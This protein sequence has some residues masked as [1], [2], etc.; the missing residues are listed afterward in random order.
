[1]GKGR[2][3]IVMRIDDVEQYLDAID[4]VD[5]MLRVENARS[6]TS[7]LEIES[8]ASEP[9]NL[10][11]PSSEADPGLRMRMDEF[12]EA[13]RAD[14]PGDG[15]LGPWVEPGASE[16]EPAAPALRGPAVRE[17][18]AQPAA[19][20]APPV[21]HE[22]PPQPA[23]PE[24]RVPAQPPKPFNLREFMKEVLAERGETAAARLHELD[25]EGEC[26]DLHGIQPDMQQ[27]EEQQDEDDQR[28]H[29]EGNPG[30]EQQDD[31]SR[32]TR[33]DLEAKVCHHFSM[34]QR[35]AEDNKRRRLC[36]KQA[37]PRAPRRLLH[38]YAASRGLPVGQFLRMLMVGL[39]LPILNALIFLNNM[40]PFSD[41]ERLH[42]T[43]FYSG[44]GRIAAT[45]EQNDCRVG[46]F[47]HNRH[48]QHEDILTAEGL[49]TGL[50]LA[51]NTASGLTTWATKCSSWIF[52]CR[53]K[54]GRSSN[55]PLGDSSRQWVADGNTMAARNVLLMALCS[56]MMTSWMHEHPKSSCLGATKFV[57]WLK[58]AL[59]VSLPDITSWTEAFT[60]MG[61]FGHETKKPTELL[62]SHSWILNLTRTVPEEHKLLFDSSH[63]VRH[64]PDA[65]HSGRRRVSGAE[66]LQDSQVYPW[67]FAKAVYANFAEFKAQQ[68]ESVE[69]ELSDDA[70]MPWE[71][72]K[73]ASALCD[74]EESRLS[75]LDDMLGQ[76]PGKLLH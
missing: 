46:C 14:R 21:H 19:P 40:E 34:V 63:G 68:E 33:A 70:E 24:P 45:F 62:G 18:P 27:D 43:E 37:L 9:Y 55:D 6:L 5:D 28:H 38:H 42:M 31:S 60:W 20:D 61:A 69:L 58:V 44:S 66:G 36:M 30:E 41:I 8:E 51:R 54:S 39:P 72:Y 59:T 22:E 7:N 52:L 48:H 74:W 1:M 57:S 56:C 76:P 10:L 65:V 23:T 71:G 26:H 17:E 64:L 12:C 50:R 53:S 73:I 15:L 35:Q 4:A 2:Q 47:D 29:C 11:P 67:D 3:D 49:L 32:M 16:E 75:D 25:A 13:Y